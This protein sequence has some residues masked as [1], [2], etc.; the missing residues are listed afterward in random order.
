MVEGIWV[1]VGRFAPSAVVLIDFPLCDISALEILCH[2]LYTI[3]DAASSS[4]SLHHDETTHEIHGHVDVAVK[5][6]KLQIAA[7]YGGDDEETRYLRKE[8]DR[9]TLRRVVTRPEPV[10]EK[11]VSTSYNDGTLWVTLRKRSRHRK[12]DIE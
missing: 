8:R 10:D 4:R 2:R 3:A 5:K 12:V 1:V 9:G 11:H 7:R 6:N